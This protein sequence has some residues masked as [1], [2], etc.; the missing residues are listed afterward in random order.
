[1][2]CA[3]YASIATL[4]LLLGSGALACKE[5]EG[6][7][8]PQVGSNS[9]WLRACGEPVDCSAE[10]LPE[11]ACGVCTVACTRDQDCAGIEDARCALDTSSAARSACE[12]AASMTIGIC[13][14]RCEPGSCGAGQACV[15]DACVLAALPDTE[16]CNALPPSDAET[17]QLE[18]QLLAL[19]Q[20]RRVADDLSCEGQPMSLPQPELRLSPSLMCAAR[21]L[22]VDIEET[23]ETSVVDS[24]G[25]DTQARLQLASY[26]PLLWADAYAIGAASPEDAL[27]LMLQDLFNCTQLTD[28]DFADIGVAVSGDAYV[29]TLATRQ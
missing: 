11:C 14:P 6:G 18:D 7:A 27:R 1:M 25:R 26:E 29:M 5:S 2:R 22:A 8:P 4:S 9:N 12:T 10:N 3:R 28:V 23:R 19:A 21:A 13:L 15:N 24:D 20:A 16:L 17:R